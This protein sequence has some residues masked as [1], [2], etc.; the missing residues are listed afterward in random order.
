MRKEIIQPARLRKS[1]YGVDPALVKKRGAELPGM[2]S[3]RITDLF[4]ELPQ[5]HLPGKRGGG[6][7]S[8]GDGGGPC[9]RGHEPDQAGPD[10]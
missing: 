4:P 5:D 3:V 1:Q 8:P 9:Q 10:G 6:R 7:G 2:T